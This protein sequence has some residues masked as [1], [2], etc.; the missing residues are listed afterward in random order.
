MKLNTSFGKFKRLHKSKHNQTIF[1]SQN[2]KNYGFVENLYKFILVKKNSFIFESVE[3]GKIK[4][5]YTICGKNP[6]KIWEFNNNNCFNY[7]NNKKIKIKG[8]PKKKYW[9]YYWKI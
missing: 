1:Y 8:S 2:C 3:K 6:D 7:I 9:I 4:G 5:R